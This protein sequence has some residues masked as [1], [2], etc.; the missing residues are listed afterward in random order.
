MY[1]VKS[2]KSNGAIMRAE[3]D[4]SNR[5][6]LVTGLKYARGLTI[7]F[8]ESRLYWTCRGDDT[9]Q[10]SNLQGS[11]IRTVIQLQNGSYP[12]GVGPLHDRLYWTNFEGKTLQASSMS[13]GTVVQTLYTGN[14]R[15]YHFVIIP[16]LNLPTNRVNHCDRQNCTKVCALT[17][18]SFR[19]VDW[20][21]SVPLNHIRI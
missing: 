1:W 7:D 5:V 3:M 15:L 2:G 18:T 13:D 9:I 14:K 19:C 8:E 17:A 4:G 11:D 6:T 12:I 20:I 21:S 10:S 16:G